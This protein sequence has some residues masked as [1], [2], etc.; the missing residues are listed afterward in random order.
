MKNLIQYV[1]SCS[2]AFHTFIHKGENIDILIQDLTRIQNHAKDEIGGK[3]KTLWFKFGS[4]DTIATDI[5]DIER[6]FKSTVNRDY[7]IDK[8]KLVISDT[9]PNHELRVF[10][11]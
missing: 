1:Y 11:S 2:V 4:D 3:N 9:E 7:I 6:D 5:K 8:M 10:Y